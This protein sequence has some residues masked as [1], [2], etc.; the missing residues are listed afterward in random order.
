MTIG[1]TNGATAS[2]TALGGPT[3]SST[4]D[5]L[6]PDAFL[7]LLVTQIRN[8]DPMEPMDTDAM[9]TQLSQLTSVERL[10]AIDGR[11]ETLGVATAGIANSQA[12]DLVGRYVEADASHLLL[13]EGTA[14]DGAFQL[15]AGAARATVELRDA[16]GHVVRT[17]E[18]GALPAG[19]AHFTW[20]GRDETGAVLPSG[21]YSVAVRAVDADGGPVQVDLSARGVVDAVT[22][23]GGYP[24]LSVGGSAVVMGDVR[25]IGATPAAAAPTVP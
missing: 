16:S 15:G 8:Q 19:P 11:L 20:D 10:V 17:L 23:E 3:S 9:M 2:S 22:Y 5:A 6:G 21:R 1:S 24:A 14:V 7:R 4:A 18:L 13:N 25:S 12:S